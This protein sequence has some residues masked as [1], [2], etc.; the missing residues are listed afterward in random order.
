MNFIFHGPLL[1]CFTVYFLR[2]EIFCHNHSTVLVSNLNIAVVVQWLS[3]VQLFVTPSTAARR[4]SL[5]FTISKSLLKLMSIELV[6]PSNQSVL[7]CP[8]LLPSVFPSIRVFSNEAALCIMW[9][10]YWNFRFSISPSS[11]YSGLISFR[12]DWLDILTVQRILKSLLQHH[13][14]KA[15]LVFKLLYGPTLTSIH[16]YWKNHSFDHKDLCRQI[17][18]S[19]FNMVSR[20]VIAF[21]SRRKHLLISWLQY[22][23]LRSV[24]Q[25]I[26]IDPMVSFYSIFLC[27][28]YII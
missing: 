19:A 22:L 5:S 11:E 27:I 14:S 1:L 13:S 3:R 8:L 26:S 6:M 21:L 18:V 25:L 23:H 28:W 7:R 16:D 12:M 9:P 24:L 17:N 10:K 4:A 20:L 2:T 15:S